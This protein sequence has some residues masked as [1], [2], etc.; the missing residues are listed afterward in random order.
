MAPSYPTA[1]ANLPSRQA[2]NRKNPFGDPVREIRVRIETGKI[3]RILSN[4]LDSSAEGIAALYKH[5]WEI[6]LFFRWVK[7]NLT[8]KKFLGTSENAIRIQIAVA[9]IAYLLLRLAH[10]AQKSGLTLL[11]FTRLVRSNLMHLKRIDR[12]LKMTSKRH[13]MTDRWR[14]NACRN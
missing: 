11:V 10:A 6:E 7:Q 5:R 4:D 8:I 2:K 9:L 12:Y 3:L 14:F 13:R 1:S